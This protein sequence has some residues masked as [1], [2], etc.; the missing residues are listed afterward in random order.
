MGQDKAV[1]KGVSDHC[2]NV[3]NVGFIY[4]GGKAN[5]QFGWWSV[6]LVEASDGGGVFTFAKLA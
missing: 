4:K 5:L 1:M 2:Q 6:A 3:S